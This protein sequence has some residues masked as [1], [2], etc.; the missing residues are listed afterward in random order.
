MKRIIEFDLEK[1]KGTV[2]VEVNE[3]E[4]VGGAARVGRGENMVNKAHETLEKSLGRIRPIA[5]AM[6]GQLQDLSQKPDTMTVEFGINFGV[7]G[8]VMIASSNAD[9]NYKITLSWSKVD[10]NIHTPDGFNIKQD[11][12]QI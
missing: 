3:P 12:R 1:D 9:T 2:L 7:K 8:D 6:L 5:E 10:I 4:P 11:E